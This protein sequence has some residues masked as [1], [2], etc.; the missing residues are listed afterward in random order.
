MRW[1]TATW[2]GLGLYVLLS[3]ADWLLT[4]ALLRLDPGAFESNPLAAACLERYGWGGLA[5]YKAG[6]VL[7]FGG[8][9][10]LL[11]RRR[12]AVAAGVVALGCAVLLSVTI[13]THGLVRDEYR[14]QREL[15]D[16]DWPPREPEARADE[17]FTVPERCWFA[18]DRP[19]RG[20][21]AHAPSNELARH[22]G[23]PAARRLPRPPRL[24]PSR[25]ATQGAPAASAEAGE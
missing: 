24:P 13:Y 9:V 1:K 14:A 21:A 23:T 11:A 2:L 7:M 22:S 19:T 25:H 15:A 17:P 8:V 20:V 10:Y 5:L 6:G 16:L 3:A 12:P 4:F 18:P